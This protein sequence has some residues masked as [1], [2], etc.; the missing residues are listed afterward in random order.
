M[1]G[2]GYGGITWNGN[3]NISTEMWRDPSMGHRYIASVYPVL[4]HA[5]R[6]DADIRITKLKWHQFE[7]NKIYSYVLDDLKLALQYFIYF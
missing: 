4:P 3:C 7:C 6:R 1:G 5:K 2:R